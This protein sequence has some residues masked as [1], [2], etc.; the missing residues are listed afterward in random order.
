VSR[1]LLFLLF[2][3]LCALAAVALLRAAP[4]AMA[5]RERPAG[6]NLLA[7]PG[8]EEGRAPWTDFSEG[9]LWGEFEIVDSVVRSGTKALYLPVDSSR[10]RANHATRVF[11]A[12]QEL[13]PQHFPKAVTGWYRVEHWEKPEAPD[14][15]RPAFVYLQVVVIVVGDPRASQL[16]YPD[17]PDASITNY[18]IRY[19]LA[20]ASEPVFT[21]PNAK[22]Q[23]V[24][25]AEPPLREWVRFELPIAKDFERLWGVTPESYDLVRVLFEARWDRKP[26][27]TKVRADVYYDDLRVTPQQ[28]NAR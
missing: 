14:D 2:I 20:G 18:Q 27:R 4:E 7:N 6:E 22:V 19:Y 28:D 3:G 8:F 17:R 16:V 1:A 25:R 10:P 23:I 11:G 24:N 12:V 5:P 15:A 26:R 13:R 21:M 9:Q